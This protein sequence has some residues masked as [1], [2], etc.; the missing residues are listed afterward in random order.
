MRLPDGY[1]DLPAG[2]LANV[3]TSLEMHERPAPRPDP[4][5]AAGTLTRLENPD[6][7]RYRRLFRRVGGPYLWSSRL[8]L[9]EEALARI[10]ADPRVEIYALKS[11]DDEIGFLELD[12]RFGDE[13]EIAFFGLVESAIGSGNGR[14]LM[15]RAIER[16]WS[17]PIRR[18]WMHTCTL[19]HPDA[20]AFY[21]R[22][23]FRPFKRQIELYDD[24]RLI[25]LLPRTA[26]PQ[27]PLL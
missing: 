20:M 24:P 22:S 25:G 11:D 2:K 23:G 1:I 10:L 15:N 26:A 16:A 9:G 21:V 5:G 18:L 27:V 8:A 4:P 19:D 12:F 17:Q 13:C 7:D 6:P 3:A 14:L